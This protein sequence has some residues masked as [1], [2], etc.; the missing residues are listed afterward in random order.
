MGDVPLVTC[1]STAVNTP[2]VTEMVQ[3]MASGS[4]IAFEFDG[5]LTNY[6]DFVNNNISA[7]DL[8][9]TLNQLFSIQCPISLNN[10]DEIPSIVYLED[11]ETSCSYDET[12][13]TT[14][15][16]C[17]QC[18]QIGNT[19]VNGN[20]KTGNYLCFAYKLLHNYVILIDLA[21]Q[22]NGDTSTTYYP[23]ISITLI[24][25]Q[26]WHYI[27]VNVLE[28]LSEQ[29]SGYSSVSSLIITYAWLDR[30]IENNIYIDTV[31]VRTALPNGYEDQ[32]LYPIDQSSTSSCVFP[33]YYNG[34]KY[35]ACTLDNNSLPICADSSNQ[36]YTCR[37][38]S[39]EGVRRLY[40]KHQLVYN[41]LNVAYSSNN[42]TIDVSFRYSDCSA[43]QL[44]VP[45]PFAV[46]NYFILL[47]LF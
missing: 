18:S 23:S 47:I 24:S 32:S 9:S 26:D 2:N 35:S 13:I 20:T 41:T 1:V 5:A 36:T 42:N 6:F 22:I 4:K 37:S 45:Y 38:S 30:Y 21:I 7:T 19:V 33:F 40:P 17:G 11:F 8:R 25:N 46:S 31:T 3:G 15:A 34:L 12:S 43:P 44:I 16:F 14:N 27:C 29:L 28:E 10:A 39:I